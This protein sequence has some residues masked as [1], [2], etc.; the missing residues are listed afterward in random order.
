MVDVRIVARHVRRGGKG[1]AGPVYV[2]VQCRKDVVS[3]VPA[4][5]DEASFELTIDV[6]KGPNGLD[7]RGPFVHGRPGE[8]FLYLSWGTLGADDEFE[9][10][11]RARLRLQGPNGPSNETGA[12]MAAG[13]PVRADVDLFRPDGR[14]VSGQL[15]PPY[16]VWSLD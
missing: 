15:G 10:F 11:S 16:L 5:T 6:V 12:A 2:G 3:R 1:R 14:P 13:N 8:R 7:F 9:M 4:D